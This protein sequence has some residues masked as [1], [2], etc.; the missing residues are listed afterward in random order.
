MEKSGRSD[1]KR[2]ARMLCA[3]SSG[4]LLMLVSS[5][6]ALATAQVSK[7]EPVTGPV[8]GGSYTLAAT[9][10]KVS[11][12]QGSGGMS[13]TTVRPANGFS[14]SVSFA[15]TGLPRG[16]TAAFSPNPA[17]ET[18]TLTLTASTTAAVGETTVTI[19]GTSG[20]LT[21]TTTLSLTVT[22]TMDAAA[23]RSYMSKHPVPGVG[24]FTANYPST[25]WTPT[26]CMLAPP[27]PLTVGNGTDFV[28][29]AQS[30]TI[31]SATGSFPFL[32]EQISDI[33]ENDV[34]NPFTFGGSNDFSLQVNANQFPT[35]TPNA[36][37]SNGTNPC[38]SGSECTGWQQ[39]VLTNYASL[40]P[41]GSSIYIQFWLIG[42]QAAFGT[43]PNSQIP[44]GW[45]SGLLGQWR[46]SNG[47]CFINSPATGVA[48]QN[49]SAI[50]SG[51]LL[52]T[53]SN[54]LGGLDEVSLLAGNQGW[55]LGFPTNFIGLSQAWT[56]AEF[57]VFGLWN[58]S[59]AVFSPGITIGVADTLTGAG[60]S[61]I[62]ATCVSNQGTTGET[63]NLSLG[64][65]PCFANGSQIEFTES[66]LLPP[67]SYG[68]IPVTPFCAC[69]NGQF[70]NPNTNSCTCTPNCS[71]SRGTMCG[72]QPDGCGG[73]CLSSSCGKDDSCKGEFCCIPK[74]PTGVACGASD[75]CG[76]SCSGYCRPGSLTCKSTPSGGF[77]CDSSNNK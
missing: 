51:Q 18:S 17:T 35:S 58:G 29:Q 19:R 10:N 49:I 14:G 57:N 1:R 42:Y 11:M 53:G 46:T 76:G 41:V 56:Q 69:P 55:A 5:W 77:V 3:F 15:A 16:V 62:S 30:G 71:G 66:N 34:G 33:T 47:G 8:K 59:Q 50:G 6:F 67:G 7:T 2:F 26:K 23:W 25:A 20:S 24:C 22:G 9:P 32:N 37:Q 68:A 28:A 61:A 21:A 48:I 70:W 74:C 72:G 60:G 40:S 27:Y 75:G 45:E 52:L 36:I 4:M 43:C 54:D 44:G 64:Q 13:R 12:V 63:N 65:C 73:K 31:M 39:F 38:A